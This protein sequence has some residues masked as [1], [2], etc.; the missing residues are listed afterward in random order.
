MKLNLSAM[1][2]FLASSTSHNPGIAEQS[3][4]GRGSV[5][6]P[7]TSLHD[8]LSS[9]RDV[10]AWLK[11][12]QVAGCSSADAQRIR[13][14]VA[15]LSQSKP[16]QEDAE[17]LQGKWRVARMQNKK[18]KTLGHVIAEFETEVRMKPKENGESFHPLHR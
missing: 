6:Q 12:E 16:R 8:K 18:R 7:A 13:E 14:A 11:G 15:V 2:C 5:E 17:P 1:H 10:Q 4:T 9:I 3:A